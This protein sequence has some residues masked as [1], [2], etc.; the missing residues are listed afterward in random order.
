[1][2]KI[3]KTKKKVFSSQKGNR[4]FLV[5]FLIFF[6]AFTLK[7]QTAVQP[8]GSGTSSDPY[9]IANV[10]NLYWISSS[11]SS[12]NKY[13]KQ[14]ADIDASSINDEFNRGFRPIGL[15]NQ[16]TGTYDGDNH[17]ISGIRV[18]N[19][20]I[21]P[22]AMFALTG[23]AA[24]IK[25][26]KLRNVYVTATDIDKTTFGALVAE[27]HGTITNCSSTGLVKGERYSGGLVGKNYG[28]IT[29]CYS[30]A[31]VED[32]P[33]TSLDQ[34]A[35][36]GGLV[37][38]NEGTISY[39]F[40]TGDAYGLQLVG[41]L[42]GESNG[43]ISDCYATGKVHGSETGAANY[44][45]GFVGRLTGGSII[46]CY[47]VGG[48]NRFNLNGY[49]LNTGNFNNSHNFVGENSAGTISNSFWLYSADFEGSL[50]GAQSLSQSDM[51]RA[52]PFINAGWDFEIET[53]NGTN[54]Y[55]D[56]DLSRAI[57]NGYPYLWWLDGSSI[58][59][60]T[61]TP[62]VSIGA[63]SKTITNTGPVTFAVTISAAA[64][65]VYFNNSNVTLNKT[66][67]AD[68]SVSVGNDGV[69]TLNRTVTVSNITGN[70]TLGIS[71]DAGIAFNILGNSNTSAGPST[72]FTVD[73][74]APTVS[75]S[76]PNDTTS[77][78]GPVTYSISYS[79]TTSV[80]LTAS[81][82]MLNKTGNANA[83]VSVINGTT[84]NPIVELSNFSGG[85]T[86]GISLLPG[87]SSDDA[88]NKDAGAGPSDTFSVI[89]VTIPRGSGTQSDPYVIYKFDNLVWV[90]EHPN[91]WN[92]YFIQIANV[93]AF[94]SQY[95]NFTPIGNS[96]FQ[97]SGNYDGNGF[98][99]KDLYIKNAGGQN[100]G[101]F[102]Y[103]SS[104]AV[105]KN[106]RLLD[107]YI[108]GNSA[109]GALVGY[110]QGTIDR[111]AVSSTHNDYPAQTI[112]IFGQSAQ[113][114][115]IFGQFAGGLVGGNVGTITNS[116]SIAKINSGKDFPY[117]GGFVGANSGTIRNCYSS[118][119]VTGSAPIGGFT[120]FNNGSIDSC[121]W[122]TETSGLTISAGGT[123]KTTDEMKALSTFI[124]GGWDFAGQ[125]TNGTDEIWYLDSL[126]NSGYSFLNNTVNTISADSVEVASA[127]LKGLIGDNLD[128]I[129]TE[130][131]FVYSSADTLP[132]MG[133]SGTTKEI[134]DSGAGFFSKK[135]GSLSPETKYYYRAYG[136]NEFPYQS[137]R[138][139]GDQAFELVEISRD[140][141]YGDVV[142]F[143]TSNNLP[144]ASCVDTTVYL[145]VN[146]LAAIDSSY[147]D[148][149]SSAIAGLVSM[150]AFPNTFDCSN[151]GTNTV[152]LTVTDVNGNTSTCDATVT[153]KD[154]TPP[155]AVCQNVTL[156]LD[157][158][159]KASVTA[160]DVDNSSS[161]NC[162]IDTMW[163]DKADFTCADVG[164]HPI[165][166]TVKDASGNLDSCQATVTVTDTIKPVAN[167]Q[168]VI[169]YLDANG[170]AS[171]TADQVDNSSSDNCGIASTSVSPN[172][173]N[174]SNVGDNAVTLTVTDGSGNSATCNAK[175]TVAD[176]TKPVA[177]CQ[178]TYVELDA[179]GNASITA[180]DVNNG[181][182]DNC[183]IASIS[184][185]PNTFDCGNLG[186]NP[187]TLTVTD[188]GG[189][190]STCEATVDVEDNLEPVARCQNVTIYL[191]DTGKASLTAADVDNGSF[192]NCGITSL[193]IDKT[194]FTCADVGD[195][196]D[197]LKLRWM[198]VEI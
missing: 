98:T 74:I 105:I 141:I 21:Y 46:N 81:K 99:I 168:T 192:D 144:V 143:I 160:A 154:T 84:T 37:G 76:E 35:W 178:N 50:T 118:G 165:K 86:L 148:G 12:W 92:K 61:T 182:S 114:S 17:A 108:Y 45:G 48:I 40:A 111:C 162:G 196:L 124:N 4:I 132:R 173:F 32:L 62:T 71:I 172:T 163:I 60:S 100:I 38:Y 64:S 129:V 13:F 183:G 169:V 68:A 128:T 127:K 157:D 174:C 14:T 75:I 16:F 55:W 194:D 103:T 193:S 171:V 146:G 184:V 83:D 130:R 56:I 97:F 82:I 197:G 58:S 150:S 33:G 125:T 109:V 147:I 123:G 88:G 80:N 106:L 8:S 27:N 164:D 39:S 117:A 138:E 131:G 136:I 3:Y 121:F 179:H 69:S 2:K 66:G 181:S 94:A 10:N 44:F 5:L 43:T 186:P 54:D 19:N 31:T 104:I 18:N 176:T 96:S 170:S 36:I 191:D 70:G 72:T 49:Y 120:S 102:G 89:D 137:Y 15:S 23:S 65:S 63:P 30:K 57:N 151:V 188:A 95:I 41:G 107:V 101:L 195:N 187:V 47:S 90:S 1:M 115:Y 22:N 9:L 52:N 156:Y 20:Y 177:S 116:Y 119:A 161:D 11:S 145:D 85:G 180:A 7:A 175:V 67:T 159:G 142:S 158:L 25:N 135:V 110:N 190:T 93:D 59:V 42:V 51:R 73:N 34:S 26:L 6:Y 134:S 77:I 113:D 29:K 133:E 149:G 185:S 87:T 140:T 79:G 28:T 198:P 189:N 112:Y 91:S 78:N 139:I 53:T 152:T 122:D 153:V 126:V 167:C 155:T 24:V 166:L